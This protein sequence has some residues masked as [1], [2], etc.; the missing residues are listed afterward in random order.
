M[1]QG[2]VNLK[3]GLDSSPATAALQ[4]FYQKLNAGAAT[5]AGSQKKITTSLEKVVQSAKKLGLT[6]DR[7]NRSFKD[8]KGTVQSLN[9]VKQRVDALNQSLNQT[10]QVAQ[11]ALGGI[12]QG[13]K[14]VLTG[15]PQGIGQ[16]IGQQLLAPLNNFGSALTGAV[17]GA[18]ERFVDIDQ[19]LRQTASISGATEAQ[20][21]ALQS[22]VIGLAKDTKFTTGELAEA[23]ITLAR[24]GQSADEVAESLP[25]IAEGAA[26]SGESMASMSDVVISAM[27][28]F[29][30]G[31]EETIDVVDVLTQTANMSNQS[32]VDLGES[33]KYV[34]P[35]AN[36][37][38][39]TLEDT[40]AALGLLA[41]AGIRGSQAGT[42][43]RSGLG[44]L[45]AA[46]AGNNSEFAEL[47]R[48]T[49]RLSETLQK[50]GADVTDS[51]GNLKRMPELLKTLKASFADLTANEQQLVAKILF[52][53]EA[54]AGFRALLSST[55]AEID[56]FAEKTNNATGV[57]AETSKKNLSGIAG[58]L[59]FL[60][61]AFDA[62]SATVG[63]F[64]GTI[65]KP[66]IDG[67]TALINVF[68]ALPTPIQAGLVAITA[69]GVAAGVATTA[70]LVFK[71]AASAGVFSGI[72]TGVQAGVTALTGYVATASVAAGATTALG[73]AKAALTA[74]A[75]A[76]GGALKGLALILTGALTKGIGL[77]IAAFG[78]LNTM[79]YKSIGVKAIA[80]GAWGKL[81][82]AM[83]AIMALNMKSI[84]LGILGGLNSMVA[85]AAKLPAIFASMAT[86]MKAFIASSLPI[87]SVAAAVGAVALAWSTYTGIM[88]G[89]NEVSATAQ[90]IYKDLTTKMNELGVAVKGTSAEMVELNIAWQ[91]SVEAVGPLQARL[92]ILREGLGL[93]T[94]ET[95]KMN[96]ETVR[97]AEEFGAI[98]DQTD[99][100]VQE[101]QKVAEAMADGTSANTRA[102]DMRKLAEIEKL[103]QEATA[104]SVG[105]LK[106]HKAALIEA[107]GGVMRMS[108]EEKTQ[109]G[110]LESLI[111]SFGATNKMLGAVKNKYGEAAG[112]VN[113]FNAVAGDTKVEQAL[114][115]AT[116]GM[117]S[118]GITFKGELSSM[119]SSYEDFAKRIDK[120]L[121]VKVKVVQEQIG[122][123]Q[124]ASAAFQ[125]GKDKEIAAIKRTEQAQS[126]ATQRAISE[127]AQQA[128]A[129]VAGVERA[130]AA[131]A[132]ASEDAIAQLE[133]EGQKT[134][135]NFDAQIAG[136]NKAHEAAMVQS[137][138]VLAQLDKQAAA[139]ATKYDAQIAGL[140]ELTPA[141]ERLGRL[142]RQR[143]EAAARA[144]GEEGL[145]AQAKLERMDAN[146]KALELE[147]QKQEELKEIEKRKA[148]EKEKAAQAEQQHK[149]KVKQLEEE[150][151]KAAEENQ[152]R[153][154]LIKE[155]A[156]AKERE[157]QN[158]IKGIR[159]AQAEVQKE[160]ENQLQ[161]QKEAN[162]EKIAELEEQKRADKEA[163]AEKEAELLERIEQL[164]SDAV[165][166]KEQ[167][168]EQYAEKR[169]GML[170]QYDDRVSQSSDSII[171][172]G[173]RA[174]GTYANNAIS[175][176]NRVAAAAQRA[177]QA[178]ASASSAGNARWSG[179]PVSAGQRYTVNELGQ[180]AFLSASGKLSMIDA[181]AFGSWKAPSKGTVIN[182]AQ[183]EKLGLPGLGVSEQLGDGARID[184]RGGAATQGVSGSESRNL[185]RAIA[186]AT[187]GDNITNNVTIQSAN[188]TQAASDMMVELT[189]I[190]RRRLR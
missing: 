118:A 113:E 127:N 104:A 3:L 6:Y 29:Q 168:E 117:Q 22:A 188:T 151:A 66:L 17:S 141:E 99:Q 138:A 120:D 119:A 114:Q 15:I 64:L 153:I 101:Y 79:M 167:A 71:A 189:K 41:N 86:G 21:Q 176:L 25:G 155:Q 112:G 93:T 171:S 42:T 62:A 59:T 132:A 68:N 43:L 106:K 102:E 33:L 100:L 103:M 123:V 116:S 131:S 125:A 150:A 28:G 156:Q 78:A 5:A 154:D 75:V 129:A 80:A 35:I 110:L 182:A 56:A 157:F 147:K 148:A 108:E 92:D 142:E 8:S 76:T 32:V 109:L 180:E 82:V 90:P 52:G 11:T 37:L 50:L 177:A 140:K 4:Q 10:K 174:W 48:G 190:K 173:N 165:D 160:L 183:T 2:N 18:V 178:Q 60:S 54:A 89:A 186:K 24:A 152:K 47:S 162:A 126:T 169:T 34:G 58:S 39:L 111:N 134:Q 85:G 95:A 46:A 105:E 45:A 26:A 16:A 107:S 159:E 73:A 164:E 146:A 67:L 9:Q 12:G 161:A 30:K 130:A 143:L 179:G 128:D 1:T 122:D 139:V 57:A 184:P 14:Q 94:Q 51:S 83:K 20:F 98:M 170:N 63:Q 13:F 49:G 149:E 84:L 115:S 70:F 133:R 124:A 72:V 36:G 19:A 136:M 137:E 97:L 53:D 44:R 69:L 158:E 166:K 77:T 23:S 40:S 121:T 172:E 81:G 27:G 145:R 65:L 74:T 96:Q 38:G 175:D 88:A 61:S 181:P 7:V 91:K 55:N 144:G 135:E 187:G 163:T 185:L 87:A 31:T